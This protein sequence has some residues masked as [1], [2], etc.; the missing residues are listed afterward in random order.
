MLSQVFPSG[1]LFPYLLARMNDQC[2]LNSNGELYHSSVAIAGIARFCR[3][4]CCTGT[5]LSQGVF[6]ICMGPVFEF[7]RDRVIICEPTSIRLFL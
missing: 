7:A 2:I 5:N 1:R 4:V 6:S 3:L